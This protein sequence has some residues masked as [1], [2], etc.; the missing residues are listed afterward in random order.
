MFLP[1]YV[2]FDNKNVLIKTYIQRTVKA[3]EI[4]QEEEA[5]EGDEEDEGFLRVKTSDNIIGMLPISCI[6]SYKNKAQ[7]R[8]ISVFYP[9]Q[10]YSFY[11]FTFKLIINL[12]THYP[13]SNPR[14][15]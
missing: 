8:D 12:T 11:F 1:L 15:T 3:G 9:Y 14:V 2:I 7:N 13:V 4:V 6:G 10:A 5:E